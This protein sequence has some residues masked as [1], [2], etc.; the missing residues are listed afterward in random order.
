VQRAGDP[1]EV[2][3]A[4]PG[5]AGRF[6][7]ILAGAIAACPIVALAQPVDLFSGNLVARQLGDGEVVR[8]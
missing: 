6:Q 3:E 4:R 2:S 1:G 7:N 5:T 8:S